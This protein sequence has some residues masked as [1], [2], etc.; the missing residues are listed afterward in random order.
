M[1]K[2]HSFQHYPNVALAG[3]SFD[4]RQLSN[5]PDITVLNRGMIVSVPSNYDPT[6]RKYTGFWDGSLVKKFTNNPAWI[7]YDVVTRADI[8]L[9]ERLGVYGCDKFA[10]YA[11]GQYCDQLVPDGFGGTEPRMTCNLWIT[12]QRDAY[13]VIY[14]LASIFRG[15]P[16]WDGAMLTVVQDRPS[17]P[18]CTY[19][20]AN[21]VGGFKRAYSAIKD[22]HTAI[23]VEFA[24][25]YNHYQSTVEYVADDALIE[26]Y[27]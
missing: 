7:F 26:R 27:G 12:E 14:D 1:L 15:M 8:G 6:T 22:R 9:G 2:T 13:D 25:K 20:Q 24:D 21:T 18:V 17:D 11:I 16:V 5:I 19:T 4:S 10:M 3:F 23:E